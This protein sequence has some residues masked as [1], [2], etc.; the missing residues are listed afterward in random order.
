MT[1]IDHS[2]GIKVGDL[3]TAYHAGYWKVTQVERRFL[4]E[5]DLRYKPYENSKVGDE[6][7]SMIHYELEYS[8][9]CKPSGKKKNQKACDAFYCKVI[10]RTLIQNMIN[11][12]IEELRNL[13]SFGQAILRKS[14]PKFYPEVPLI[15]A[16]I[17]NARHCVG[18]WLDIGG[19]TR[20]SA[21]ADHSALLYR[22]LSGK[23][24]LPKPPPL[25]MSSPW[26]ELAEGQKIELDPKWD[27]VVEVNGT[28]VSVGNSGPFEWHDKQKRIL[29]HRKSGDLF[30]LFEEKKKQYIQKVENEHSQNSIG[31]ES[32]ERGR[33]ASNCDDQSKVC[34]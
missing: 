9:H 14:D 21:D 12:K 27:N 2:N 13:Y 30:R 4:T 34:P 3:I 29:V 31:Q 7:R 33:N 17:E 6:Y 24:A 28:I 8:S 19:N 1:E 15:P 25:R 26:Y 22:L 18:R 23:N 11:D 10:D 32:S 5:S 20:S 16:Q